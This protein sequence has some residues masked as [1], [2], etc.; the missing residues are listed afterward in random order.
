MLKMQLWLF[1]LFLQWQMK[2]VTL[3]VRWKK[4]QKVITTEDLRFLLPLT[5]SIY[6]HTCI[7]PIFQLIVS[8]WCQ[9]SPY[10]AS[11]AR[12][13]SSITV[14]TPEAALWNRNF[15]SVSCLSISWWYRC[16]GQRLAA[17]ICRRSHSSSPPRSGLVFCGDFVLKFGTKCL[18]NRK[19][20][21]NCAHQASK[22]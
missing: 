22:I 7:F 1:D 17:T 9:S 4:E 20:G 15:T 13:R 16:R 12:L 2:T 18:K 14:P 19:F 3:R 21:T 6:N 8:A 10:W 11:R 5:F